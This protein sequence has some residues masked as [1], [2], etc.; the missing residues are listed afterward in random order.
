MHNRFMSTVFFSYSHKDETLRD[1]L[2]AHLGLLRNQGLIEHWHD[3][4]IVA[5]E[6]LD[7]AIFQNLER[8][9]V[10][11]LLIS[12][13]FINSWYCYSREMIRAMERHNAGEARVIPVILRHCDWKS[14]PF[15][16]LMAAPKDGRAVTSWPDRD[17]AFTDVVLQVRKAIESL[18]PKT[19]PHVPTAKPQPVERQSASLPGSLGP[20]SSN[21]RLKQEFSDH[22]RDEFLRATFDFVCSYFENSVREIGTRNPNIQG[23][24]ERIDSR[25]MHA[26]LYRNGKTIA[27]CSVRLGGLVKSNG[28]VIS[29]GQMHGENSFNEMLSIEDGPHSL[30]M[31]S[32]GMA[33]RADKGDN[34]SQEG[35]AE[36]LWGLFVERAQH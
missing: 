35:S 23:T 36:L 25:R 1:E 16:K 11:L 2:E 28:I 17:E 19:Q 13:D 21:L 12:S 5:G 30:H 27:E 15:G 24:F 9:D 6:E 8:A 3:R 31:R 20:R 32:L 10:I 29:L 26:V 7:P 4:R 22:D 33:A 34:L 14:A 18:K